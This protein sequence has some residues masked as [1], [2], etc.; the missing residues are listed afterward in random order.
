MVEWLRTRYDERAVFRPLLMSVVLGELAWTCLLNDRLS[1]SEN[2]LNSLERID[3]F[4]VRRLGLAC[5]ESLKRLKP[6]HEYFFLYKTFQEYL[7][8][9]AIALHLRKNE[10]N[11]FERATLNDLTGKFPFVCEMLDEEAPKLFTQISEAQGHL[12]LS[13]CDEALLEFF[14]RCIRRSKNPKRMGDAM[15]SFFRFPRVVHLSFKDASDGDWSLA[16]LLRTCS[17]YSME[18]VPAELHIMAE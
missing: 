13:R 5:K 10:F 15:C 2:E 7:A 12:D 16:S 3:H 1:F 14:H 17:A 9:F 18:P 8:A 11:V 4:G 6:Q